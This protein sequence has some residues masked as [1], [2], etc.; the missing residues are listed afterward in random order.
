MRVAS[1]TFGDNFLL[2]VNQ[3]QDHTNRL[4]MQASSGQKIT[5]PEDNPAAMAQVMDLQAGS[6]AN[7]QYQTNITQLQQ[8]ATATY[9][10]IS[11]LKTLS[12][13]AGE[14]TTSADS[15]NS[16]SQFAT[17][18][19]EVNNMIQQAVQLANTQNQGTYLLSGTKSTTAPFVATYDASGNIT[20][21]S[22]QGNTSVAQ[23]EVSQGV[24]LSAQ[25]LGA[26]T[27]G[28]GPRGLITDSGSGA[29]FINHLIQ[30]RNDL[31]SGNSTA[32]TQ[33][34]AANLSKDEDNILYHV[35]ANGL[36]QTRLQTTNDMLTQQ[37]QSMG[38]EISGLANA[39]LAS[40]LT[41]LSQ[42]QTAY[43]AA[44]SSGA[45]IMNISLLNYIH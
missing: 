31:Q 36:L 26:N 42:A 9:N 20:A 8:T 17:Y 40:T 24:T 16:P 38:T 45:Q 1:S 4:Q 15:L 3:L 13:R 39:D 27:T 6:K 34:D 11:G 22:Y 41:Q 25:T 43:Q 28:S 18:A 10:V 23:S 33:T 2:E 29:D 44:L 37:S 5:L 21:V 7:E 32:I 35:S 14:I 12:D 30:L 19:S